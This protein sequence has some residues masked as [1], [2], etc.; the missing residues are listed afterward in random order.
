M[1]ID[2]FLDGA[3]Q[4]MTTVVPP[5]KFSLDTESLSDGP[6]V[7][8]FVAVGDDGVSSVRT[9]SFNVQNGPAIAVHGIVDGDIV[10]GN[11]S[12]LANAY[13]SKV[14]D[15][16]EPMRIETPAPVPTWAWVLVLS[17]LA[18]G[19]GYVSLE[20]HER[21]AI[22]VL[23]AAKS[24]SAPANVTAGSGDN[25]G[26]WE[27]LG[28]QVYGN[29]CS[30]CHQVAGGG[31]P[32]VFPPLKGN[33]VVNAN[34]PTEHIQSILL[35]LSDKVIDGVVYGAPMPPF[36]SSLS[37]EDVAAVVNHERSQWGNN[38]PLVT[39]ADVRALRQ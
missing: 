6:H 18:W 24:Q 28:E 4:S 1:K 27:V 17:I 15:E 38:A 36:G 9:V 37:D 13:S 22:P 7:L 29:N 26:G 14:G 20:L 30:A 33:A 3:D 19:V 8:R 10:Q 31:L 23:V 35:G 16:F 25:A 11:I 21:E 34:N 5:G 39:P 12:V 32:G 2:V